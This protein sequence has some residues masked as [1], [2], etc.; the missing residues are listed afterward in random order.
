MPRKPTYQELENRIKKL[1]QT[2]LKRKQ[3]ENALKEQGNFPNTLINAIPI[4]IFYKDREGHYLGFNKAFEEFFGK[5]RAGLI[6][7]SVFD[8]NPKHL[9]EIY[10]TRCLYP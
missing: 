6:G 8:I 7:K 2:E 10:H 5:T 4:P 9:A 1:E 3:I